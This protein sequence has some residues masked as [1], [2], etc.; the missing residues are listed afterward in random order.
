MKRVFLILLLL[1]G[2]AVAALR[3]RAQ[4]YEQSNIVSDI[5]GLAAHTDDRLINAWGIY[6][7][8][9]GTVVVTAADSGLSTAYRPDGTPQPIGVEVPGGGPTGLAFNTTDK[10]TIHSAGKSGP[11]R[12][13]FVTEAGII[14]GWNP[15]V[16]ATQAIVALDNSSRGAI[17]KG[18]ALAKDAAGHAF[19]YVADF[20][21]SVVTI[22]DEDFGFVRSFTDPTL[23]ADFGPFNVALVDGKI[24]VAFA[25]Q[26]ANKEDEIAGAGFGYVSVFD[27]AGNFIERFASEG[28]LNAPWAIVR[29][30]TGFG[31][32]GGAILVGNFGDGWINVFKPSTGELLG[33]L[34]TPAGQPIAIDGL[35]GLAFRSGTLWFAAGP[36]LEENGLVGTLKPATP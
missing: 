34:R 25:M 28:A 16:D 36:N 11:A 19:L 26:D 33:P 31:E 32:F 24:Y 20:H 5:P 30:P 9:N 6:V 27:T 10:F 7:K 3:A 13:L 23:P 2:V 22:Y 4:G 18:A 17:Y 12:F 21:N 29:A 35:W 1:V 14:A 8:R 15:H